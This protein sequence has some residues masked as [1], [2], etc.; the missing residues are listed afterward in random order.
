MTEIPVIDVPADAEPAIVSTLAAPDRLAALLRSARRTYTPL[1]LHVADDLSRRWAVRAA[2]PYAGAVAEVER[3]M[4]RRGAYLLNHSYE[5]GCTTAA[6]PDPVMGGCTL[7]RTLDWPFDGLGEALVVTRWPGP[8]GLY[9][10][11]T[12]P[13]SVGVL[14]ACA[15]GRFAAAINQPPLPLPRWGRAIGWP[16][17]RIRVG[18][19]RALP[20]AHLLRLVFDTCATFADAAA[21]LRRTPVCIPAIYTLAGPGPNEAIVIERT[22]TAAYSPPDAVAANHWASV[23]A[24]AGRPRNPSSLSRRAAMARVTDPGPEWSLGWLSPPILQPDTRLAVMANPA[25]GRLMAQGWE[26]PGAV[27]AVLDL[28]P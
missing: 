27:T 20:P 3:I 18:R 19:S 10:S 17:A 15:P 12:W 13:G 2:G 26:K 11:V 14:T 8:A 1:G 22:A 4:G 25:T 7:L 21:M 6:V 5:W 24:P 9:L 28:R 23:D 16:A